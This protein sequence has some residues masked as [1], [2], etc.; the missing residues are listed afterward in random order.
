MSLCAIDCCGSG[1]SGGEFVSL[2]HYERD[3]VAAVVDELRRRKLVGRVA[4]WG[5]SMGASTALLYAAT[6]DP[7]VAAVVADSPYASL[8]Q[9]CRELVAKARAPAA[10]ANAGGEAVKVDVVTAAVTEAALGLVRASVRHRA[11]FDIYD[12][13][14]E[15]HVANLRHSATPALFMHG[16]LDDFVAPR[17][18]RQLHAAHGG[19]SAL[20]LLPCDHQAERPASAIAEACL[21]VYDKLAPRNAASSRAS[22]VKALRRLADDGHLGP[23][24][25]LQA[26]GPRDAPM[27]PAAAPL[28]ARRAH[29]RRPGDRPEGDGGSGLGRQRQK[30]IGAL[31]SRISLR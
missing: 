10:A 23:R 31:V 24:D 8:V 20:V 9:L 17:H 6:R 7:C 28:P 3:D 15:R 12:V 13:A 1:N 14:P 4:L 2:G 19:D 25:A 22:Y 18:A 26:P 30:E 27:P 29:L 16:A 5:R 21:F 11:A